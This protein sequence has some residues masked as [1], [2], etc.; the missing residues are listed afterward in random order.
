MGRQDLL[1][2][3]FKLAANTHIRPLRRNNR[4]PALQY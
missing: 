4:L 2:L 3:F 1:F